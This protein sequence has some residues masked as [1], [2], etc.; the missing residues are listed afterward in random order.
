MTNPDQQRLRAWALAAL[1]AAPLAG[2]ASLRR[3]PAK[4][5]RQTQEAMLARAYGL[6]ERNQ[7]AEAAEALRAALDAYPDSQQIRLELAYLQIR[8]REWKDA[9]NLLDAAIDV[10]PENMRLRM[11]RGYARLELGQLAPAADEFGIVSRRSDE[12]RGQAD[13][14]LKAIVEQ[15]SG[16]AAAVRQQTLLDQ[17]Y[18]ELKRGE[19]EKAREKFRMALDADPGRLD[20]TKQLAYMSVADGD[21]ASAARNF[22]GVRMLDP[23]DYE[24]A[25]E[26]GYLY[27]SLHNEKAAEQAF[28]A[29][30]ASP[31]PKVREAAAEG[32]ETVRAAIQPLFLDVYAAPFYTS[33]FSDKIAELEAILGWRP[34]LEGPLTLYL[35]GRLTRDTRSRTGLAP[36]IYEDNWASVG[37]GIRLQPWGWNLNLTAEYDAAYNL[38]RSFE[39]P[40]QTEGDWRVVLADYGYL[41]GPLR[42]FADADASAGFYS[43]YRNN[44]IGNLQARAGFKVWDRDFVRVLVFAP[45]NV[46]RDR[47]RD[48]FNN[49][50][51]TGVGAELQPL[52]RLNFRIRAEALRGKYINVTGGRDRNPYGR[53]YGDFRLTLVFSTRFVRPPKEPDDFLPTRPRSFQW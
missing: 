47:N 28:I 24:T 53:Y 32:R 21:L 51:E 48:Y 4:A 6:M 39:H 40:R 33:R 37:P 15:S 23:G 3:R 14:A 36:Q 42:T 29:A 20:V 11:E 41:G 16:A 52:T 34:R 17:G 30:E 19:T 1:L 50:A 13:A 12:F 45:F 49:V 31:D 2:C 43:R 10:E 46:L 27:D 5:A 35:A 7:I 18:D 22:A 38:I 44:V 8:R 9:V 25:L 26:L